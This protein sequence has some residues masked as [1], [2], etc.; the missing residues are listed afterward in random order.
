M[1]LKATG[2][3]FNSFKIETAPFVESINTIAPTIKSGY[4]KLINLFEN[5]SCC[6]VM[7]AAIA[8]LIF[9]QSYGDAKAKEKCSSPDAYR[10]PR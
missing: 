1:K 10:A 7:S 8:I 9:E 4:F 6:F 2:D 5:M 3:Y